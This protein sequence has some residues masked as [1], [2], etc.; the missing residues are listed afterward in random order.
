MASESFTVRLERSSKPSGPLIAER[1]FEHGG[2][3]R[4]VR[5]RMR[6]PRRDPKTGDYWCTFEISGLAENLEFKV[7][8]VD[9]LQ[10]LQLAVRAAGELLREKGHGLTWCG[11]QELG[12]PRTYPSFLSATAQARIERMID[13]EIEK[14]SRPPR[15]KRRAREDSTP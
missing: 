8:G 5:V 9:S 4:A 12:F 13:R 3:P 2:R 11:D 7:W 14:E 1:V 6:K 10:A 15:R